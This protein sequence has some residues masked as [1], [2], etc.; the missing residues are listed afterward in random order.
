MSEKQS[1]QDAALAEVGLVTTVP[2]DVEDVCNRF[3][4]QVRKLVPSDLISIAVVD[5]EEGTGV[6]AYTTG[7]DVPGPR[8]GDTF[9]LDG[10]LTGVAAR[11]KSAVLLDSADREHVAREYPTLLPCFDSGLRSFMAI[12]LVSGDRVLGVLH[13][14]SAC[15]A[16][17]RDADVS[18]VECLV[19]YV[20]SALVNAQL[21]AQLKAT[22]EELRRVQDHLESRVK[23]RTA[24]LIRANDLLMR[25]V[26]RREQAERALRASEEHFRSLIENALD[27]IAVLEPDGAV[28]YVSPSVK[29]LLGYEPSEL[30]GRNV[31]DFVH[32]QD[33]AELLDR[34][35][36]SISDPGTP[37]SRELRLFR[38]RHKD[39]SW[40]DIESINNKMVQDGRV[41]A[42]V[43]NARD[44]TERKRMEEALQ[45]SEEKYRTLVETSPDAIIMTDLDG[46]IVM[47]NRQ[48]IELLGYERQEDL[49]GRNVFEFIAPEDHERARN[50]ARQAVA[51]GSVKGIEYTLLCKKGS[52]FPAEVNVS[53]IVD[54]A[55]EHRGLVHV[56]RDIT[57]RR[58]A[59]ERLR[60]SEATSRALAHENAVLAEIG[61]IITSSPNINETYERLAEQVHK[62]VLW[63]RFAI[64]LINPE[65]VTFYNTYVSGVDI[66]ERRKGGAALLAGT[67]IG[68]VYETRSSLLFQPDDI[69]EVARRFPRLALSFKAGLRSF[70]VVPLVSNDRVI[71]SLHIDST[72]PHAYSQRDLALGERIAAQ[73]AGV[74]AN[75]QL[76][77]QL[78]RAKEAAETAN[79]AKSMFL[80]NMSHEIRTPLNG[81]IAATDLLLS[82]N[83]SA[84]HRNYLHMIKV[85][86]DSLLTVIDDILDFSRIEA[87][88]LEFEMTSFSLRRSLEDIM[89]MFAIRAREKGLEMDWQIAPDVPDQL[90]GDPG[91]LRQVI[92]NLVGNAVK[93]TERGRVRVDVEVESHAEGIVHLVFA[94]KDTGPGIPADKQG[95]LFKPF[96][97][98]DQNASRK[99]GGTG[100]GLAISSRLVEMMGGR[101]W[102]ESEPGQGSTFYFTGS[103]G[104][105][106]QKAEDRSSS[107][108]G[109]P[110]VALKECPRPLHVLV[111]D[112]NFINQQLIMDLLRT[113]GHHVQVA[114]NGNE[115]LA[116]L[117]KSSFEVL[118]VDIQMPGMDGYELCGHIR[119]RDKQTGRHTPVLA[120][121]AYA[122]KGDKEKCLMAGMDG[123]ISKPVRA[124]ELFGIVESA[125]T[126]EGRHEVDPWKHWQTQGVMDK[127]EALGRLNGNENLLRKTAALFLQEYQNYLA[128]IKEA[129][130]T[131][132]C[133]RLRRAAH[134]LKGTLGYFSA[135]RAHETALVLE[136]LARESRLSEAEGA[137]SALEAEVEHLNEALRTLAQGPVPAPTR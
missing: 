8:R 119:Q 132:D 111:V 115:A 18:L 69:S 82:S 63:D 30:V 136:A 87:G 104:L 92:V 33:A 116:M 118:L 65:G 130:A 43:V 75:S 21:C 84:Q 109:G 46:A 7:T 20:A 133:E 96:C 4:E 77:E 128:D 23:E 74:I 13:L 58:L 106:D 10:T 98:I 32:P 14:Q 71:G 88:K 68:W 52:R 99:H 17:Y 127:A 56:V 129:V 24:K 122:M 1:G 39:G 112:D 45:R 12:P 123:Y 83:L 105:S 44:I 81:V 53:A 131:G 73:I 6:V 41:V 80:A 114:S 78:Q 34:F 85:S 101:I 72:T 37:P 76:H 54:S 95:M 57:Q 97:Q 38:C 124:N 125:V 55:G 91:R 134:T 26:T 3:A 27:I 89:S 47:A 137:Y 103:F 113:R 67:T 15:P 51:T 40:R 110:V 100:L 28:R 50:S 9:P 42:M 62:L 25:E 2:L 36:K 64:G 49:A 126:V 108:A 11:R 90:V 107:P 93:F 59:E 66:T 31:F 16:A 135:R 35:G 70:L 19:G 121:T 48:V 86:A 79:R 29:R 22:E 120:I 94:V 117:E 5:L 60:K 61:K 102:L